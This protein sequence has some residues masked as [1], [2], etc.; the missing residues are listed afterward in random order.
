MLQEVERAFLL[1]LAR[2]FRQ[3][4]FSRDETV[5]AIREETGNMCCHNAIRCAVRHEFKT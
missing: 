1:R 3:C 5:C 4:G 2:C